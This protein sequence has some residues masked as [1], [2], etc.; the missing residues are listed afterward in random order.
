[1]NFSER[2]DSDKVLPL[3]DD[4]YLFGEMETLDEITGEK[5]Y[6][7]SKT[8]PNSISVAEAKKIDEE[9]FKNSFTLNEFVTP[10]YPSP[11]RK[12]KSLGPK[13]TYTSEPFSG[14]GWQF[15]GYKFNNS[16]VG[17]KTTM[18]W[19]SIGDPG[20][21]GDMTDAF[22]TYLTGGNAYGVYLTQGV[23]KDVYPTDGGPDLTHYSWNPV[24]G[25]KYHVQN[26]YSS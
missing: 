1:M 22:N 24:P 19:T 5:T 9:K 4:G 2:M 25:S 8:D 20:K 3:S 10:R 26:P 14:K 12:L 18:R 16:Y 23:A 6:Q 17:G 13:A 21:A 7:N 15:A 11:S